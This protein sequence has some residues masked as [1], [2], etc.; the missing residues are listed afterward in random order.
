MQTGL[1]VAAMSTAAIWNVARCAFVAQ[2]GDTKMNSPGDKPSDSPTPTT[3]IVKRLRDLH[4]IPCAAD[5]KDSRHNKTLPSIAADCIEE[6]ER[7]LAEAIR[8]RENAT[9]NHMETLEELD[10][11]QADLAR[12][13]ANHAADL[14][15]TQRKLKVAANLAY[16]PNLQTAQSAIAPR[17][18]SDV[19]ADGVYLGWITSKSSVYGGWWETV[20]YGD[21]DFDDTDDNWKAKQDD[22]GIVRGRGWYAEREGDSDTLIVPLDGGEFKPSEKVTHWV[23]LPPRISAPLDGTTKP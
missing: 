10:K 16:D 17:L 3:E 4:L 8:V 23:P 1:A 14:T 18:A 20:C 22:E 5:E 15:E 7:E 6:L 9:N 13:I 21:W 11:A 2:M 12:A 19:P